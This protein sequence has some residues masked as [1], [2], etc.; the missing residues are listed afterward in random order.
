MERAV[1][2]IRVS[3][4]RQLTDGSSIDTQKRVTREYIHLKGYQ[5]VQIFTEE[6]ESAKTDRRTALLEM[7]QFIRM[8]VPKIDVVVFPKIDRFARDATDY[9]NLKR[10]L[11]GLGVR[12]ESVGE[13][14]E[15]TPAGRFTE[16]ILASAAQFD[17][18][19]RGERSRAGLMDAVRQGRWVWHA[20]LGYKN[21]RVGSRGQR[22]VGNIAP[23]PQA[24]DLIKEAFRR[25]ALGIQTCAQ[26]RDWLKEHGIRISR[27]GFFS[28]IHN[29]RYI[30][31]IE[32][33]GEVHRAT[34]PF[35]ALIEEDLFY[36]A[37]ER[38]R[39]ARRT[40]KPRPYNR[41]NPDFPL[42]G[43]LI[44]TCG[45]PLSA[46]W[47]VGCSGRRYAHYRCLHCPKV[48][49]S[50]TQVEE[51]FVQILDSIA[52]P[53]GFASQLQHDFARSSRRKSLDRKVRSEKIEKAITQIGHLQ[54]SLALKSARGVIPDSVAKSQFDKLGAELASLLQKRK[55]I[56]RTETTSAQLVAFG[57]YILSNF[58]LVW[59][60]ANLEWKKRIQSFLFPKGLLIKNGQ[61][62]TT[63]YGLLDEVRGLRTTQ[64]ESVVQHGSKTSELETRFQTELLSFLS[65][66]ESVFGAYVQGD[67]RREDTSH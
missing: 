4:T 7:L 43:T 14:L 51:A 21:V 48:N 35:V 25:L 11:R 63:N 62:R 41:N 66:I 29:K 31:V 46:N 37:Q 54:D 15:D 22:G 55:E 32:A 27:P 64:Y 50:R 6:A 16:F 23:D 19:V 56:A 67:N 30:G 12:L 3:G 18:E 60:K 28:L 65:D 36:K 9:G 24:A 58:G 26:V 17:N 47:S 53:E 10:Q 57:I 40:K 49:L 59:S 61:I 8:A 34:P 39:L 5:E 20:P 44:C 2:Y 52:L 45:K 1:G 42:R 13:R 33:F 38:V